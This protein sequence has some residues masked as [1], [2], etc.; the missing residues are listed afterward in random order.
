[1]FKGLVDRGISFTLALIFG[2]I[3]FAWLVGT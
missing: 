2:V 3:F 1:M